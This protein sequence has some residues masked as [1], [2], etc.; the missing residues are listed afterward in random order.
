MSQPRNQVFVSYAH[1]DDEFL[2][3]LRKHLVPLERRNI[4]V[5][6]DKDID[7]GMDW[8][9]EIR[10]GLANA[11]VAVLLISTDFLTSDFITREELPPLLDAA[12]AEG[13]QILP[14]VVKPSSFGDR[15]EPL[16]RFQAV[17]MNRPL[18]ML[19]E[20]TERE[21]EFVRIFQAIRKAFE[22]GAPQG[23]AP[24]APAAA[25]TPPAPAAARA[26]APV[27]AG[28]EDE[29]DEEG[30]GATLVEEL[31]ADL[32]A[33]AAERGRQA[34][35]LKATD[36]DEAV[37]L[38]I[39]TEGR[40]GAMLCELMGNDE[41]PPP[42]QMSAQ[43]QRELVKVHGFEMPESRGDRFW[44]QLEVGIDLGELAELSLELVEQLWDLP[45]DEIDLTWEIVDV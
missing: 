16:S 38:M 34:L 23:A 29:E 33:M 1:A 15:D 25:T 17:N 18:A 36:G 6:T 39:F 22:G 27:D 5:W 19:D 45:N 11:K 44:M 32:E 26:A 8:N 3:R 2:Q 7:P 9:A 42:L 13:V 10:K 28:E 14:V 30:A 41:L 37:N 20:K 31:Q 43:T 12:R 4:R 21:A 35:M 24:A 40:R